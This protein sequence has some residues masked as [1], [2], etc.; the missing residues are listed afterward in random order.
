MPLICSICAHPQRDA[1]ELALV[2]GSSTR[3]VASQFGLSRSSVGRHAKTHLPERLGKG[4]AHAKVLNPS[5][6]AKAVDGVE[7]IAQRD[8]MGAAELFEK[9][10]SLVQ[11][12]FSMLEAAK[13]AGDRTNALKAL[14]EARETLSLLGKS[15]GYWH[16]GSSS[17]TT[18]DAR[19][20]TVQLFGKLTEE[21][22]RRLVAGTSDG[23]IIPMQL[24]AENQS[25]A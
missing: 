18:I 11:E 9:V 15:Q 20:Q 13:A 19:R 7:K 5:R 17:T 24:T 25:V 12:A 4:R 23:S 16:D 14:R 8:L 10:Q 3:T 21:E 6:L 1:L 22:L 2:S